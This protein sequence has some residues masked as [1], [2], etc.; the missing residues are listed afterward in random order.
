M[1]L[2]DE[3]EKQRARKN[4]V[5]AH[6]EQKQPAFVSSIQPPECNDK[7]YNRSLLRFYIAGVDHS[8]LT[9]FK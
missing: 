6:T 2:S 9:H 5:R 4:H 3:E 8:E 7:V 1:I